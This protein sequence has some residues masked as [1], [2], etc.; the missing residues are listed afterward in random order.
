MP[1]EGEPKL[2]KE[3]KPRESSDEER[4]KEALERGLP[5][6]ASWVEIYN[7]YLSE[8]KKDK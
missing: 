2:N 4:K 3:P 1:H 8:A 7:S 6:D 5:E